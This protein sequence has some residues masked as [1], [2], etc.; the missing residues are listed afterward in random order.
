MFLINDPDRIRAVLVSD[1]IKFDKLM[2]ASN[3]LLGKGLTASRAD[4]H[5]GQRR[6]I[7]PGFRPEQIAK[8]DDTM[9][10]C[11][12]HVQNEWRDG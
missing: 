3:S 4:L 9:A 12:E 1:D 5:R 8:F 10:E 2:D 7:Q 11:A 6:L